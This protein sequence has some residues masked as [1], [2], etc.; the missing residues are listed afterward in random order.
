MGCALRAAKALRAA[1]ASGSC[2]ALFCILKVVV[3][4]FL[5]R[6]EVYSV[7]C[8]LLWIC[9]DLGGACSYVVGGRMRS[10]EVTRCLRLLGH[11]ARPV[12]D[13]KSMVGICI[14]L[15]M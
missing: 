6:R 4:G 15:T 10:L 3:N 8:E 13:Y 11:L 5:P 12:F 9:G 2:R 7:I 14:F 1:C